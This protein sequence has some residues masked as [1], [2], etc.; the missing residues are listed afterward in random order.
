MCNGELYI[1]TTKFSGLKFAPCKLK[2]MR[3]LLLAVSIVISLSSTAQNAIPP[4]EGWKQQVQGNRYV[5][6]P[7]TMPPISFTYEVMPPEK[8][9]NGAVA[10]WLDETA[11]N[12]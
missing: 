5:F 2:V 7:N 4:P 1:P 10:A 11:A 9:V 8:N 6:T 12:Y 3:T